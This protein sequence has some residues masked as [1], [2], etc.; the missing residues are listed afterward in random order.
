[1]C[2][3]YRVGVLQI[4]AA[5]GSLHDVFRENSLSHS[6]S[7]IWKPFI[8]ALRKRRRSSRQINSLTIMR[9]QVPSFLTSTVH[10]VS[11]VIYPSTNHSK[12][13]IAAGREQTSVI[14]VCCTQTN[15]SMKY[16]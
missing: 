9:L 16:I 8:Y 1:M 14:T 3:L 11:L 5:E 12:R 2:W 7:R 4:T 15:L 6:L 13:S 10:S